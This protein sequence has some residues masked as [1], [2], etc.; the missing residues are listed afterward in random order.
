V[1]GE[2]DV[3]GEGICGGQ[4]LRAGEGRSLC[5]VAR[6]PDPSL[7]R[8]RLYGGMVNVKFDGMQVRRDIGTAR[9]LVTE[10]A[11][12]GPTLDHPTIIARAAID[13][14]R[15]AARARVSALTDALIEQTGHGL[16]LS[17]AVLQDLDLSGFDLRRATLSR[18]QLYGTN[19]RNADL[20]EA[21]LICPGLERTNFAGA[22]L[23]GAYMHALGAQVCDFRGTDLRD[24][25]DATGALFHGC[26]LD[27]ADLRNAM[28][29]G[30]SFYQTS[31]DGAVLD[32][33]NLQACQIAESSCVGTTAAGTLLDDAV[34]TRVEMQ[35]FSLRSAT[36][37]NVVIQAP[38]AAGGLDLRDA[39]LPGLR[40]V[41][42]RASDLSAASLRAH[43]ADVRDCHLPGLDLRRAD[44]ARSSWTRVLAVG[45][46]LGD[47]NAEASRWIACVLD[48]AD[49]RGTKAENMSAVETS[50]IGA[51]M[52]GFQGRCAHLRNCDLSD[53]DLTGAYLYRAM[54]TGDPPASM[55]LTSAKFTG[56]VLV[57][58]YITADLRGADMRNARGAYARLN[59]TVLVDADLTGAQLYEAS[60][61]KCD[62]RG[63]SLRGVAPPVLADRCPGLYE[64][65]D[66]ADG[67]ELAAALR[68]QVTELAESLRRSGGL[69][70]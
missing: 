54:I 37:R 56:A 33:A 40:L 55:K 19:L 2:V 7:L 36:G 69:S 46:R 50:A 70:T 22:S 5:L 49:L 60:M 59:Q 38:V 17:N 16:E 11:G 29:S 45:A 32:G 18:A 6:A 61:V 27:G 30:S 48:G 44:I 47:A 57:Q 42:V 12:E 41:G 58:A 34:F 68:A 20:T 52:V 66:A 24:L 64:A 3:L 9:R 25:V 28:L 63:A 1:P 51:S 53:V 15:E 35:R 23:R 13:A 26:R 10:D 43:E 65:L 21:T 39:N 67:T 62:L 4:P 8:E 31:L 14:D